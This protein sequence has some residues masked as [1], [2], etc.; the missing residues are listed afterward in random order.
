MKKE[1]LTII[2]RLGKGKSGVSY[3]AESSLGRVVLKEMHDEEVPYYRFDKP[4]TELEK[5]S[6]LI[7]SSCGI[8]IPRLIMINDEEQ[9]LIKEYIDGPTVLELLTHATLDESM[10][11][12][13]LK[14]E[15]VLKHQKLNIDY[16][17]S[18]FVYANG[19]MHYIDYEHNAYSQEWDFTHWGIYYWLNHKGFSAYAKTQDVSSINQI[20]TGKPLTNKTLEFDRQRVLESFHENELQNNHQER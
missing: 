8:R 7:L 12:E 10:I 11:T 17:P 14:W 9:Y 20:N 6:Y 1:D 15:Q 18:N 3:L 2:Q 5:E 16:Y 19:E 4:K 13:M